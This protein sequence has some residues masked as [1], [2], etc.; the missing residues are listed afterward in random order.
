MARSQPVITAQTDNVAIGPMRRDLIP[1]YHAWI[2]DLDTTRFL[3]TKLLTLDQEI[4]WYDDLQTNQNRISFT[5]YRRPDYQPIGT[6][7][8]HAIDLRNR[9]AELGIMIG[10]SSARGIGLGTETVRLVCDYGFNAME[11]NSIMLLTFGW[12]IAG[13]KAYIKA[14]F[15]EIGR[16]RQARFF[17][18]KYWDDIYYDLLREEFE[19]PVLEAKMTEG[20]KT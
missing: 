10:E 4:A 1:L 13:Q 9:N 17:A 16:R 8:L 6:V 11:L 20:L 19:S 15:R 14:G 12:N 18:G 3:M 2:S 7:G 5:V